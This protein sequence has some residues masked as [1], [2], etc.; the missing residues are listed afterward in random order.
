MEAIANGLAFLI[1]LLIFAIFARIIISWLVVAGVRND[2]LFSVSRALD[3][4]T[5]PIMRPLRRVIPTVGMF[6]FTPMVALIILSIIS[7]ILANLT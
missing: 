6:D 7:G 2:F 5:E 4:L 3:A 1:R